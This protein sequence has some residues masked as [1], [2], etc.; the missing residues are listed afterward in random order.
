M[1]WEIVVGIIA[2]A[3]FIGSV[4]KWISK[5]AKT[6]GVLDA[7]LRVLD[8]TIKELKENEKRAHEKLFGKVEEHEKRLGDH[9]PAAVF[10]IFLV[11]LTEEGVNILFKLGTLNGRQVALAVNQHDIARNGR[12]RVGIEAVAAKLDVIFFHK[13]FRNIVEHLGCGL[14][15]CKIQT[16]IGSVKEFNSG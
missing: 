14:F 9:A 8:A 15:V 6:L 3:G 2:L 11:A 5:L 13:L 16:H 10:L 12:N 1:T 4:A 7:T